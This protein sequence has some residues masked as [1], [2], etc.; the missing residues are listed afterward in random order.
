MN[1]LPKF[2]PMTFDSLWKMGFRQLL[3]II[4]PDAEISE[5]SSLFKR[6]G[7]KQDGRGKTPGVRGSDGKW[8]S[9]DWTQHKADERDIAR[10]AQMGAGVGIMTGQD[11]LA[12]DADT[13]DKVLAG[14]ILMTTVKHFGAL[15]PARVGQFPKALYLIRLSAPMKYTRVDFG[16]AERVECL[17]DG[18]QFVAAG[19]HP[20][21][22]LPYVWTTPLVPFDQL[23]IFSPA[24]VM[25][26][27]EELRTI[28]PAAKPLV[29]EG[30]TADVPQASLKGDMEAVTKAVK[31]TPNTSAT[32]GTRE[33]YRDYGYA[34]KAAL[35]DNGPEAFE[36]F[37]DWC[38]RWQDGCNDP[39]IVAADWRRMKSPYRRGASWIYELA[40][41]HNPSEFRKVD[42]FFDVINEPE[43]LFAAAATIPPGAET[44]TYPILRIGDI[45]NRPPPIYLIKRHFPEVSV[46]F[47]YA[48]PGA[49]KTF[50]AL[51][52]ALHIAYGLPAW[53]GDA[54]KAEA[55]TAV[56]YIAAEGSFGFRNRILA[57]LQ[58]RNQTVHS[59]RF[60]MIER[61]I[62]FMEAGDIDRLLRTVSSVIGARPVLIVV[63]TVSQAIPGADE[64]LQKEMTLFVKAC[65]RVKETFRCAVLGIH[66]AGKNGDMRGSTVLRGAGDFVFR[67]DRKEGA[68]V[69]R[70][71]C[72]KQKDGPD[73]WSEPYRFDHVSL[74]AGESSWVPER[75]EQSIG[76]D[77]ALTPVLAVEVLE[78]MASVWSAGEPWG[79]TYRSRELMAS[80][81]M[82]EDFD[83]SMEKAEQ[84]IG[85]WIASGDIV[86]ATHSAKT[87]RKGFQVVRRLDVAPV[88]A[89]TSLFD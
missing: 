2:T 8:S 63:D 44:D 25:A 6:V 9:F 80:R 78:A 60:V 67:L 50:L 52:A 55:G 31:A 56:V 27:L 49:G 35:P 20:K 81:R 84:M 87:K 28:L 88:G 37:A 75:C 23:P 3:P 79:R 15:L 64:N 77:K 82:V 26:F 22:K 43:P 42:L 21:T 61:T 33:A 45:V 57:W 89:G 71:W 1:A 70:L 13:L 65:N 29:T 83:F 11:A 24:Q 51:D 66:H 48:A 34:I 39:D 40:Q 12:I 30:A 4:P 72:E 5:R 7:T 85:I 36:L 58:K 10:W 38:S 32:F 14:N 19:V 41:Q 59:D 86:E 69:G 54:I 47:L 46:G 53:H 62:D 73:G 74:D 18:R 68:S 17:S 76:P 16:D